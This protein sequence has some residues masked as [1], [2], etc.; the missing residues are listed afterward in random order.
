MT[1]DLSFT[2]WVPSPRLLVSHQTPFPFLSHIPSI[3]VSLSRSLTLL[4]CVQLLARGPAL[5]I[6][7]VL[8]CA[9]FFFFFLQT[10]RHG[11][12]SLCLHLSV[13]L[14]ICV[15][16]F[17][18]GSD[19]RSIFSPRLWQRWAA[20]TPLSPYVAGFFCCCLYQCDT[21]AP[22]ETSQVKICPA[23]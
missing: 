8:R 19:C 4:L 1:R 11:G 12:R 22:V 18:E 13:C 5:F 21:I 17:C 7:S 9:I 3:S 6:N 14:S 23:Y 15:C 2:T 20:E 10:H 16:V